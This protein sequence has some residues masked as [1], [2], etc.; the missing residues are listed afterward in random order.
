MW[1]CGWLD[2]LKNK[3]CSDVFYND[4][5]DDVT[6][7]EERNIHITD[8]YFSS[9]LNA[10]IIIIKKNKRKEKITI[11]KSFYYFHLFL[12]FFMV[13]SSLYFSFHFSFEH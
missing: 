4:N 3:N 7:A 6:K 13:F 10:K 12:S 11:M 1:I 2:A 8:I 9:R 5:D